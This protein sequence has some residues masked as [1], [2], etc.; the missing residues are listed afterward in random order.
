MVEEFKETVPQYSRVSISALSPG[1]L[2]RKN[3]SDTIHFN[4][5]AS[6][7]R[8]Q[9]RTIHSANQL[10][11]NGAVS[12]WCE[13][14]AAKTLGQTSTGVIKSMSKVNDQLST[15]LNPQEIGSMV[16]NQMRT[17]AAAGNCWRDH[18]QRFKVL[19]PHEQFRTICESPW[20]IRPVSVGM[21]H[22]T[23]DGMN[24]GFGIPTASC[25]E[26]TLPRALWSSFG[27]KIFRDRTSYWSQYFLSSWRSWIWISDPLYMWR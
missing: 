10:S 26:Y 14:L 5:D 9:S 19:D 24:D 15:Q 12:S 27:Y 7:T 13:E 2:K 23:S 1:I 6:N 25:R 22:R 20:F 8:L 4:A 17:H 3:N 18:L 11:I 16:Q 21:C